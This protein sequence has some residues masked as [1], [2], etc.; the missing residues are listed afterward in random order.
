[1][2][3]SEADAPVGAP[4]DARRALPGRLVYIAAVGVALIW[5]LLDQATKTLAVLSLP[6][7]GRVG[8]D[9]WFMDL[10]LVRN[11]NA[12]FDI[13]GLFP[14]F[15]LLITG[16]VVVL[17]ARALPSTDRLSLAAAYGLVAGGALGN[18][19]DRIFRPPGFP[20]GAVIDFLDLRWWPVFNLA[21]VGIVVGAI[22]VVVLLMLVDREE[23]QA[24]EARAGHRSVRP[25]TTTPRR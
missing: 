10:R 16:L 6:A 7:D 21:D 14:G 4:D 17:I 18:V 24:E 11:E 8:V 3:T 5:F 2:S 9:L 22:A 20:D 12:A 13:P 25:D 1:M 19:A 23:R 15:F